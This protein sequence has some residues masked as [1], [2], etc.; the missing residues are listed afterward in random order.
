MSKLFSN[1]KLK[2]MELKN[3]IV[4]PPMCMYSCNNEDGIANNWHLVHY[5][6]RA[7]G[8]VGLII[9]EAT[10]VEPVGRISD[11]DL[12]LWEDKQIEGL[13]NIV[14]ECHKYGAKIGIQ[15]NHAGRKSEVLSMQN[16]APSAIAFN[17]SYRVPSEMTKEDIKN[18]VNNF[19]A[20]AKRALTAGFDL[21]ELH[22]AHGYLISEFLSPLTNKRQDEYGGSDENRVRF[23]KEVIQAVKTVWPETKPLILRV[24]AED[25]SEG[26]NTAIK[27]AALINLVKNEGIDM[28]HVSTGGVVPARMQLYPGYQV[29]ASEIINTT[30]S[31]K[32]IA[33]GLITSPLMA[34]EIISN[35]RADLVFVGRELLRNPYWP[36]EAA[37]MLGNVIKWPVQYERSK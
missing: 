21:I 1:L 33:G 28:V 2:D 11:K 5:T 8:G 25:Y 36:L 18:T 26:G 17:E 4:M 12:G 9:V 3:R 19:K 30:C 16:V 22:G 24:S 29:K 10:G 32:T 15:L 13:K 34:E 14:D 7:I 23:L 27:T 35:D 37:K 20:A 31:I 6:T